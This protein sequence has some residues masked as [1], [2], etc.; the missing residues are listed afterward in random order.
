MWIVMP[1][2]DTHPTIH[3]ILEGY[4]FVF[5]GRMAHYDPALQISGAELLGTIY[6]DKEDVRRVLDCAPTDS[7]YT[8]VLEYLAGQLDSLTAMFQNF[9]S[10]EKV[11][12]M[13][14]TTME[15]LEE[16]VRYRTTPAQY[17]KRKT[18]AQLIAILQPL[19]LAG[20]A[21][22]PVDGEQGDPDYPQD[23]ALALSFH[24]ATMKIPGVHTLA[25]PPLNEYLFFLK[26]HEP[27]K[28]LRQ[29]S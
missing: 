8:G 26:N 7:S 17:D 23:L 21:I 27:Q 28:K 22:W 20:V 16:R 1:V 19:L 12:E 4:A 3:D 24:A 2:L 9:A 13:I 10:R 14:Q 6:K 25:E 11:S 29:Q 15:N 5:L 18:G